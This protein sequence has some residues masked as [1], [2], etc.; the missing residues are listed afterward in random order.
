MALAMPAGRAPFGIRAPVM[1]SI[2]WTGAEHG[3]GDVEIS[4]T[5]YFSMR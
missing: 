2:D 3:D 4:R 5:I 1:P